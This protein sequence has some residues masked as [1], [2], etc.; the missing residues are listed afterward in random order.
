V[1]ERAS[2]G[3]VGAVETLAGRRWEEDGGRT[4]GKWFELRP[5]C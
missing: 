1:A 5:G 3:R 2:D 4:V